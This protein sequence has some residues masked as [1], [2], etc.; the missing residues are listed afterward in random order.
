MVEEL[1]SG[2][3]QQEM[4]HIFTLRLIT[5]HSRALGPF[6]IVFPPKNVVMFIFYP[7]GDVFFTVDG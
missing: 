1:K 5:Q 3:K 4:R 7:S 6:P 2:E